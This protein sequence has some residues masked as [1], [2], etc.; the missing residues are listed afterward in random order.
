MRKPFSCDSHPSFLRPAATPQRA[1]PFPSSTS[2]GVFLRHHPASSPSC[3]PSSN[4]QG[5]AQ[6][7][8]TVST[9]TR[10]QCTSRRAQCSWRRARCSWRESNAL[11]QD[12][13]ARHQH[14]APSKT[15]TNQTKQIQP[16]EKS[17]AGIRTHDPVARGP[18]RSLLQKPRT[19]ED[20]FTHKNDSRPP[21]LCPFP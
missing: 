4:T 21:W 9:S 2:G 11:E 1:A 10:A 14:D 7:G 17:L 15:S 3:S 6:K 13:D 19:S 16:K 20:V 12:D 8:K 18:Q 5:D